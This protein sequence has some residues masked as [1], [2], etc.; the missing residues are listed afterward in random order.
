M[1]T[2]TRLI[3]SISVATFALATTMMTGCVAPATNEDPLAGTSAALAAKKAA[4]EKCGCDSSKEKV[5][6]KKGSKKVPDNESKESSADGKKVPSKDP[7]KV[8]S[9][10]GSGSDC[11]DEDATYPD[12]EPAKDEEVDEGSAGDC[13]DCGEDAPAPK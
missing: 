8:P 6:D 11:E 2:N 5:E 13:K 12:K 1:F 3:V 4:D 9:K 7:G 10:D